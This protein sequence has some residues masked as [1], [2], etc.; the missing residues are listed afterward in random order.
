MC[1]RDSAQLDNGL[2]NGLLSYWDFENN[3]EDTAGDFSDSA[4]TFDDDG[5][6]GT[7]VVFATEGLFGTFGDFER[8]GTGTDN[9]VTVPD[10]ADL[11]ASGES[12]SVSVW[13][14]VDAFNQNWQSIIVHGENDD[15]RLAR[16]A[17]EQ[18]LSYAGG[19][20]DVPA[21]TTPNV[22][23]GEWHHAVGITEAGVST[24]LWI[25]LLYTSPSPRDLSTSR[26]PSSA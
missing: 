11:D 6:G 21:N 23:D 18:G 10:S 16:R 14:R 25:C 12:L 26:M 1:I 13:F 17:G 19:L 8:S 20:G 4:N 2:N 9:L 3:F 24:R 22:N 7:G 15:W 5:T